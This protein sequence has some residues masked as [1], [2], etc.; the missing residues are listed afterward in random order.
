MVVGLNVMAYGDPRYFRA[1]GADRYHDYIAE[2]ADLARSLLEVGHS[3]VLFSSQTIADEL[4]ALDVMNLLAAEPQP[5]G[6]LRVTMSTIRD[7]DDL[8]R[9]MAGCDLVVAARY[10]SVVLAIL[11][12]IP[13]IGI[14]YQAKT[15]ELLRDLGYPERVFEIDQVSASVLMKTVCTVLA[16]ERAEPSFDE[17]QRIV[18][19]SQAVIRQFDQV[20]ADILAPPVGLPLSSEGGSDSWLDDGRVGATSGSRKARVV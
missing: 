5:N 1:L 20:F 19:S 2:M 8:V 4:A 9:V 10:H 6:P 17:R 13:V 16:R 7:L 14:A 3:V 11:F 18:V 12:G 15:S